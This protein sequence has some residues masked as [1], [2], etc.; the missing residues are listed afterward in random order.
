MDNKKREERNKRLIIIAL[1]IALLACSFG[2]A[3]Y[4]KSVDFIE[5]R[6]DSYV[7]FKGGVL[8][9]SPKKPLTGKIYPTMTSGALAD[10]AT[11]TE[12]GI[13]DI[14]VHFTKPGQ[15]A[16]YSF[17]GINPTKDV[18]YLNSIIFGDKVCYVLNSETQEQTQKACDDIVM[19]VSVKNDYFNETTG[20]IDDHA[21]MPESNEPIAVTIKY[22]PDGHLSEQ[23]FIVDFGNTTISYG[24]TD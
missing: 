24:Q 9:I 4:S 19:S 5:E 7:V 8:S 3:A 22:L 1:I 23:N 2:F 12:N 10:V 14:N 6:N 18:S 13:I 11:L 17:Y 16:T 20:I 21:L 15:S